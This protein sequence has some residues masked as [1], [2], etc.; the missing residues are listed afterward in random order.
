MFAENK[1]KARK[2]FEKFNKQVNKHHYLDDIISGKI[3]LSD[4][5]G[6]TYIKE[7]GGKCKNFGYYLNMISR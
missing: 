3:K 5:K 6:P 7:L 4:K 2:K 1:V